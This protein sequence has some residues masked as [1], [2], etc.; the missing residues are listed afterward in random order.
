M[1]ICNT[2]YSALV[3]LFITTLYLHSGNEIK[4]SRP[5]LLT[6][7]IGFLQKL[8]VTPLVKI[9]PTFY[10]TRQFTAAYARASHITPSCARRIQHTFITPNSILPFQPRRISK[11]SLPFTFSNQNCVFSYEFIAL[12]LL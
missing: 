5:V 6:Y 1:S 7:N 4:K 9:F 2:W 12:C 3:L 8:M 11:W 10:G